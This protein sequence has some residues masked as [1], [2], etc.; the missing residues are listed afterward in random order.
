MLKPLN[1]TTHLFWTPH[2]LEA[3]QKE[4]DNQNYD[5]SITIRIYQQPTNFKH[6]MTERAVDNDVE[7]LFKVARTGCN[8]QLHKAYNALHDKWFSR[9]N[10][11]ACDYL[12]NAWDAISTVQC[13][14]AHQWGVYPEWEWEDS[15]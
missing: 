10:D 14:L 11:E 6:H 2:H 4:W 5:S 13:K 8:L 15:L 7:K 9:G 12:A 3:F 1:D